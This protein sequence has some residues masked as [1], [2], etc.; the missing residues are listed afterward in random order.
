M[1]GPQRAL[2]AYLRSRRVV[3]AWF[4]VGHLASG[5]GRLRSATSRTCESLVTRGILERSDGGGVTFYR[6]KGKP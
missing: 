2:I 5:T 4:S 1:S 6:L 3:G